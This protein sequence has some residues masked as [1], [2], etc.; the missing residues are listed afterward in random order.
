MDNG[1]TLGEISADCIST[2]VHG[3]PARGNIPTCFTVQSK[4]IIYRQTTS[5][6][7]RFSN[8]LNQPLH[9]VTILLVPGSSELFNEI[10]TTG[11]IQI[12][13]VSLHFL[14]PPTHLYYLP[15]AHQFHIDTNQT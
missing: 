6:E 5:R 1:Q 4:G 11:Y 12:Q 9:L 14:F 15:F 10:E 3:V 2:D 13:Q 7:E 8:R